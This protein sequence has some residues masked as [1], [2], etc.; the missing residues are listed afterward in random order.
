MYVSRG[1]LSL[2]WGFPPLPKRK[3]NATK[4]DHA[5]KVREGS[6]RGGKGV[7][8]VEVVEARYRYRG[9]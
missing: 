2:S 8:K 7:F 1:V 9:N 3:S 6:W 4:K 5:D